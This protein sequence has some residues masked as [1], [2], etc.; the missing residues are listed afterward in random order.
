MYEN[1]LSFTESGNDFFVISDNNII[2]HWD[3]NLN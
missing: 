3:L 2:T 1:S